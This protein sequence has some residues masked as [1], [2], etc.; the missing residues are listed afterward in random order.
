M[1]PSWPALLSDADEDAQEA[2]SSLSLPAPAHIVLVGMMGSGKS[3]IG[4]LLAER[5]GWRYLDNDEAVVALTAREAADVIRTSGEASLHE[6][7]ATA[8]LDA[9]DLGGPAV[10][11]AAAGVV[12][13]ASCASALA[14]ADQVV[15]LRA[16]PK[17]LRRRIGSGAGRRSDATDLDWLE[18]RFQERDRIYRDVAT[19]VVDVD[20]RTPEE[21]VEAIL[22]RQSPGAG[23]AAAGTS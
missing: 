3:T 15:Y 9:L 1:S 20:E 2:P 4:R 12:M 21:I 7:E 23:D 17:T 11:A 14:A 10:I 16:R 18:A 6:A 22:A 5:L 19:A 8:L 13:D